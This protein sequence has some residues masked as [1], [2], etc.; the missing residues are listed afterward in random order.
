MRKYGSVKVHRLDDR[1]GNAVFMRGKD[2]R[3][4][5]LLLLLYFYALNFLTE[6]IGIVVIYF[7][8]MD[9][10]AQPIQ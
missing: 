1:Q 2:N 4:N 9:F 6:F 3:T 5:L 7:D 8:T 10:L